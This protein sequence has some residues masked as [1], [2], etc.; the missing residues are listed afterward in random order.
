M[1]T[2]WAQVIGLAGATAGLQQRAA[3]LC[4]W[5]ALVGVL[6]LASGRRRRLR[7]RRIR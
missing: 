2:P 5:L 4:F 3:L 1:T 7:A 6:T